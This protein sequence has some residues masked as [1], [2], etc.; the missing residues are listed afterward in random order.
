MWLSEYNEGFI[1]SLTLGVTLGWIPT[2]KLVNV[3]TFALLLRW[4]FSDMSD[5]IRETFQPFTSTQHRHIT[6]FV[7][8][9]HKL[10]LSFQDHISGT[11]LSEPH[12]HTLT[13]ARFLTSINR[14]VNDSSQHATTHRY[15]IWK[16]R[17]E[18]LP[19][20]LL[21]QLSGFYSTSLLS[22]YFV[23]LCKYFPSHMQQY[24]ATES[25]WILPLLNYDSP[26]KVSISPDLTPQA[27]KTTFPAHFYCLIAAKSLDGSVVGCK[28]DSKPPSVTFWGI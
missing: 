25:V 8:Q 2:L 26:L 28:E 9:L 11:V 12:V 21:A 19:L 24:N 16:A 6:S 3:Q 27:K 17:E 22:A 4:R 10:L 5:C 13:G 7:G 15:Y 14:S 20:P 18:C 1:C 23:K